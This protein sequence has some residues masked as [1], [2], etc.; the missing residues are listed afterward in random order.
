LRGPAGPRV[1]LA[2][3]GG[4]ARGPAPGGLRVVR[5]SGGQVVLGNLTP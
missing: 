4:G 5:L 1:V 2:G 3:P